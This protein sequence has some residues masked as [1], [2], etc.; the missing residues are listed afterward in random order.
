MDE[1]ETLEK[2]KHLSFEICFLVE[3]TD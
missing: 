3:W 1:L 2:T